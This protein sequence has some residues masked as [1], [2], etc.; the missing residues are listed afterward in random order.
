MSRK[1]H[2]KIV[3]I[4][5][6]KPVSV[7][8]VG[9]VLTNLQTLVY[10]IGDSLV[11]SDFRTRGSPPIHVIKRCNLIFKDVSLGSFSADLAV[12]DSQALID[13]PPL[14]ES[15]ITILYDMS[16]QV[17][18]G[19]TA[20]DFLNETFPDPRHRSRVVGDLA[21]IW[22]SPE[23]DYELNLQFPSKP[24]V[25]LTQA[26]RLILDGLK[27]RPEMQQKTSVQGVLSTITVAPRKKKE[28]HVIG[29]DGKIRFSM[30]S[31]FEKRAMR[32]IG[33]PVT[34]FG[35][36]E[37]DSEGN[38]KELM[39]IT[40]IEPFNHLELKRIYYEDEELSLIK[41]VDVEVDYRDD[42]WVME[43]EDL[44]IISK[45]EDYDDCL[46]E[47]YSDFLFVWRSFGLASG[48]QLSPDAKRIRGAIRTLVGGSEG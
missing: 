46:S 23:D 26:K 19:D 48:K 47:F 31:E 1:F 18:R 29:P 16:G 30:S 34:A 41:P 22:P 3:S 43:N 28:L 20:E 42:M 33:K 8:T 36:A 44:G 11:G 6:D 9:R 27:C 12:Q 2:L 39:N 17:E 14:G 40:Q 5:G 21:Q 35:E 37:Y 7:M 10:H 4:D 32:H 13:A 15:A 38:I 25:K 45:E 24:I